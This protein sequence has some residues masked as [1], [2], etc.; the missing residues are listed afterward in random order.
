M[1]NPEKLVTLSTQHRTR[2]NKPKTQYYAQ[3]NTNNVLVNKT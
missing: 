3:T 1:D 2:T